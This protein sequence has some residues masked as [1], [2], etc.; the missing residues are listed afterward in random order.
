MKEKSKNRGFRCFLQMAVLVFAVCMFT[1]WA[2][3]ESVPVHAAST[4]TQKTVKVRFRD[5]SG[6]Y[7]V[8]YRGNW[9]LKN[10]KGVKLTGVQYLDIPKTE[11]LFKGCYMFGKNGA[12]AK[13]QKVYYFKGTKVHGINF[14]N[15]HVTN[16]NGRFTTTE[17]GLIHLNNL[18]CG[19][20]VYNGFYYAGRLGTLSTN[21]KVRYIKSVRRGGVIFKTGY[22][23]FYGTGKLCTAR[24]MHSVN[25]TVNKKRFK[26]E[27]YF[28]NENG[29]ICTKAG[30]IT[31][32][33]Q[34]YYVRSTGQVAVNCWKSGYYLQSDGTIAKSTKTGY[35]SYVDYLGHKSTRS[36]Y[37]LSALKAE[38]AQYTREYG[39]TWSVYI[40]DLKTG[41]TVNL[42][43]QAM[44]PA[45]TIKAFVMASTFDQIRQ[46]KIAYN[47]TIQYLLWDM[48][49]E[50]DNECF[51]ELVRYHASSHSFVD[52]TAVVNQYLRKN[53]YTSTG[54]HSSLHPSSSSFMSDGAR[55]TAS[56]RDCGRLLEQ[57]YKGKC[58][59]PGYSREMLNLLLHQQRRWK[60]P[61]GLPSGV[62]C[63]NKTGETDSVQHDIAIIYGK[64]TDYVLCVFS[65][66]AGED[67]LIN[68]IRNIS[69]RVYEYLN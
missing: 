45:S 11:F 54:C 46:G 14:V 36:E 29:R 47:S 40:K 21:A 26:G 15:Y 50:S 67:H 62:T 66:D 18:R 38:L 56:A 65:K 32:R 17:R 39:G 27:Y 69:S 19:N 4:G 43:D 22:Y 24:D 12:L 33:G 42:Y 31:F 10:A 16:S 51:N 68:G 28:S 35:G 37:A 55:N 60:I 61:A 64:K 59:S 52:G 57:I 34:K 1:G 49:T 3:M 48:I 6:K 25:M 44:Y 20:R 53:S 13:E 23:Y 41:N 30:W 9:Y 58:V 8:K 7:L 2:G 63:A 5:S